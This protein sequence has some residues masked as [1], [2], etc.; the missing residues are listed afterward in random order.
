[1]LTLYHSYTNTSHSKAAQAEPI[2][3][4]FFLLLN[5]IAMNS[6][7]NINVALFKIT[8]KR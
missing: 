2:V 7:P 5:T 3:M 4:K 8:V 1:M 6:L